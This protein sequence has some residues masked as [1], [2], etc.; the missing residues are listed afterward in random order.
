MNSPKGFVGLLQSVKLFALAVVVLGA[1][2]VQ[3]VRLD[4]ETHDALITKLMEV[5][6]NLTLK[7]GSFVPTTLRIADLLA[8]RARL[9]DMKSMEATQAPSAQ[10]KSDRL[11]AIDL[12]SAVENHAEKDQRSRA[13]LQKAQLLQLLEKNEQ[14]TQILLSI[15]KSDSKTS[16]E[17][18]TATDMLADQSFARGD[19]KQA[20]K[21]YSEIRGSS[22]TSDYVVYRLAWCD[23][24]LQKEAQAINQMESLLAKPNLDPGLKKE[25]SRDIAIFYARRSFHPS[26]ID[27]LKSYAGSKEETEQNLKLYSDELKRLG[28]K[29]ESATVLLVYLKIAGKGDESQVS[30][31]ELFENYVHIGQFKEANAV[32]ERISS[33]ACGEQCKDVQHRIHR[34]LRGWAT[35]EGKRPSN[36]LFHAFV[37]YSQLKPVDNNAL[38][39]G[40]KTAQDADQSKS[41]LALL[42]ILIQNTND[43][44][45]LETALKAQIAAAE[46]TKTPALKE[47]AYRAYLDRGQDKNLKKEIVTEL[48]ASMI[49]AKNFNDAESFAQKHFSNP[50]SDRVV[51]EQLLEIYR[52]S[53]QTEKERLFSL[54]MSAGDSNTDYFRNYKRLSLALTKAKMDEGKAGSSELKL[55][56]EL[57]ESKGSAREQFQ[58]LNDSFLVALKIEDFQNMKRISDRMVEQSSKLGAM[59]KHLAFEKRMLVADLELDFYK[60]LYFDKKLNGKSKDPSQQFRLAV[61]ARLSGQADRGLEKQILNSSRFSFQQRVWVL[62]NQISSDS[63]PLNLLRQNKW[64]SQNTEVHSRLV[65]MAMAR[66]S[67]SQVKSYVLSNRSLKGSMVD[68]L[69]GRRDLINQMKSYVARALSRPVRF[70]NLNSF[71]QSLEVQINGIKGFERQFLARTND[72]VA[73]MLGQGYFMLLNLKLSEQLEASKTALKVSPEQRQALNSQIDIQI[74]NLKSKISQTET[75]ISSLWDKSNIEKDFELV[76]SLSHP[77]QRDAIVREIES[78]RDVSSGSLKRKWNEILADSGSAKKDLM[79]DSSVEGLYSSIRRNPFQSD[80]AKELAKKEEARGN[81]LVSIFLNQREVKLKGGI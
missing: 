49:E 21:L 3:A 20:Q 65:L 76:F 27:K 81:V 73:V 8:D 6:S 38:L 17:F 1:A 68:V 46:K 51:G 61:K 25:A 14:A 44:N 63:Q 48:I 28:K 55:L 9:L 77:L 18:W 31:S 4:L 10:A 15:R 71:A 33:Q 50:K 69:I 40:I 47:S 80:K 24:N 42:S 30:R 66:S 41:A 62:E 59:E 16:D 79:R 57:S 32:L 56:L 60:S 58:I 70:G 35:E 53:S 74:N 19:F 7:D 43:K 23:L 37:T 52:K 72:P 5:R 13:R 11:Q 78:W 75:Q 67:T 45:V 22:K 26:S 2:Q 29:R 12:I 54:K 64:I 39:F 36:D 34:T